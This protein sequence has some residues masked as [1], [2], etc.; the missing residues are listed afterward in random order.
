M[1]V[2]TM[3]PFPANDSVY[4]GSTSTQFPQLGA[5]GPSKSSRMRT[6][7]S[8]QR[9]SRCEKC[10]TVA[11]DAGRDDM[12]MQATAAS[13][14]YDADMDD[15]IS[16]VSTT[17]ER[18]EPLRKKPVRSEPEMSVAAVEEKAVPVAGEHF[19]SALG[20]V[21]SRWVQD[22]AAT[23]GAPHKLGVFHSIRQPG[24]K[25]SD[26]LGRIRK[27]FMCSDECF[28]MALVYID[29]ASKLEPSMI[30]C[31]VTIHRLLAISVMLAAK[32]HDDTFFSNGYY[33]KAGGLTMKEVNMLEITMLKV[34]KWKM[35][36]SV[37]EYQLYHSLICSSVDPVA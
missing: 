32:F 11:P 1:F 31:D 25:I 16:E 12:D 34:L 35:S 20:I 24:M 13:P 37:E 6:R 10:V 7:R 19:A 33:A 30:V 4:I 3:W 5:A 14:M 2:Q 18:T 26:Y 17:P 29:R 15:H 8:Q 27:Y 9:Q 36:V 28:V 22:V 23:T 21:L